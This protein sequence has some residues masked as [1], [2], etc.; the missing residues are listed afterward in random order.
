M[1]IDRAPAV[2][3]TTAAQL[4]NSI[5]C[6]CEPH[7]PVSCGPAGCQKHSACRDT[8]VRTAPEEES[9]ESLL[10]LFISPTAIVYHCDCDAYQPPVQCAACIMH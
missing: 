9:N 8:F 10:M 2:N 3:A 1:E 4:V 5:N 6:A 7:R